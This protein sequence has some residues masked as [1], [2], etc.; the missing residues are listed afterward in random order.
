MEHKTF[1]D[2]LKWIIFLMFIT[3]CFML[4][5]DLAFIPDSSREVFWY[6]GIILG[7]IIASLSYWL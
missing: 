3:I 4:L 1:K 7:I 2:W 5:C 6:C